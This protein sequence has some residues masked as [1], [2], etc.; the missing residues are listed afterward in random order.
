MLPCLQKLSNIPTEA[1]D[2]LASASYDAPDKGVSPDKGI[3]T[4]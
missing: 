4:K 2:L 3:F 1:V